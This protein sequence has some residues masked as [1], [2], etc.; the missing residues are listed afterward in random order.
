MD[1]LRKYR[2][3]K[4]YKYFIE[5][6]AIIDKDPKLLYKIMYVY[7]LIGDKHGVSTDSVRFAIARFTKKINNKKPSEQIA[8][9]YFDRMLRKRSLL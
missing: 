3:L 4:G 1:H 9:Y 2:R 7:K 5:A 8:K 6:L